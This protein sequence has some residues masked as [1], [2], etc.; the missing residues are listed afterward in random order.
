MGVFFESFYIW[1][2]AVIVLIISGI[3]LSFAGVWLAL[4]KE[5]FLPLVISSFSSLGVVTAF[6]LCEYF[7]RS[8][9][10][11]IF[12]L[13]FAVAVSFYLANSKYGGI[14]GQVVLYLISSSMILI[15]GSFIRADIHD[16]SSVLFGSTVLAEPV[17]IVAVSVAAVFMFTVFAAFYRK[18]LFVTTDPQSAKAFGINSYLFNTLLYAVLAIII[19]V[20]NKAAG[21]FPVLGLTILPAFT[22]LNIGKKMVTVFFVAGISAAVSSFAG[23][24]I[25]FRFDL[26]A[27]ASIIAVATV[28]YGASVVRKMF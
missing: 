16:V 23:Y 13:I 15:T 1:R 9:S 3:A 25:S 24:F 19:S 2:D 14:N 28:I 18:L 20:A 6:F 22:G 8:F 4:K 11:Y 7:G 12:S 17:D 10:P 5:V 26:P 21:S 27:G